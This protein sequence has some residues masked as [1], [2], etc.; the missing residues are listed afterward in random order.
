MPSLKALSVLA[1]AAGWAQALDLSDLT[2]EESASATGK[3]SGSAGISIQDWQCQASPYTPVEVC[4][5]EGNPLSYGSNT[6]SAFTC[7]QQHAY[8]K[9]TTLA[10][11]F[12]TVVS[13]AVDAQIV[14]ACYQ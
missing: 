13:G 1:A 6:E 2:G 5:V 9:N 7:S 3:A 4:D 11:G 12:A 14:G 10:Y 8:A